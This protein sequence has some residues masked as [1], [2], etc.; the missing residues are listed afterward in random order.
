MSTTSVIT[1]A[2][3]RRVEQLACEFDAHRNCGWNFLRFSSAGDDAVISAA[4]VPA[5]ASL[6]AGCWGTLQEIALLHTLRPCKTCG[7]EYLHKSNYQIG[8]CDCLGGRDECEECTDG[9]CC[10]L[11]ENMNLPDAITRWNLL[12]G[13]DGPKGR[14]QV[15]G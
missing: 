14:V 1:E 10:N 4:D 11:A 7:G 15:L 5:Y 3:L 13:D 6:G 2:D 8:C 9:G 12:Y